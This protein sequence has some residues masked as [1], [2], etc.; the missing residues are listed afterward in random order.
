MDA[1]FFN[2]VTDAGLEFVSRLRQGGRAFSAGDLLR[3]LKARHVAELDAQ[4]AGAADP[5]AFNWWVLT[6]WVFG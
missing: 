5:E 6:P 2:Y 4:A 3:R 1:E